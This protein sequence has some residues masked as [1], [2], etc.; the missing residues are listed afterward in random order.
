MTWYPRSAIENSFE[1]KSTVRA[2]KLWTQRALSI[3]YH[4]LIRLSRYWSSYRLA[5][6]Y[7]Y[8]EYSTMTVF[9][10]TVALSKIVL[11]AHMSY[12]RETQITLN[13][14]SAYPSKVNP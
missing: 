8:F 10:S 12:K 11:D 2:W 3:T 4:A 9:Q 6:F 5:G 1:I 7:I 14:R 13:F